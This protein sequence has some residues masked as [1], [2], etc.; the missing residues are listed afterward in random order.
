MGHGTQGVA[1][2]YGLAGLSARAGP[3][4][5]LLRR[6]HC[7]SLCKQSELQCCAATLAECSRSAS[8]CYV[9]TLFDQKYCRISLN[10]STMKSQKKTPPVLCV[11]THR[12]FLNTN[13]FH[14]FVSK[15]NKHNNGTIYIQFFTLYRS[16]VDVILRLL[17]SVCKDS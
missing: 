16:T 6:Q 10:I 3:H 11:T 2:G 12:I 5:R 14:N 15:S 7:S 4:N 17:F 1:L 8:C 9:A 13:I